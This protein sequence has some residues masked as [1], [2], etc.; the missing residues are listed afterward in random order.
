[1]GL[2]L[3][4][5]W[6][7]RKQK[8]KFA[9][10][11]DQAFSELMA[12]IRQGK[13]SVKI[14]ERTDGRALRVIDQPMEGGGWVATFE[15][16]TE[17][18][19]TE[20]ERDQNR[21]FLDLIIDNV[22]SAIFVKEAADRKYVLVNRSAE[23]LWG[24]PRDNIIGKTCEEVFSADEAE[25]IEGRADHLLGTTGP[26]FEERDIVTPQ[27][28]R[29]SIFCR[30]LVVQD[31]KGE[32][33][34]LLGVVDDVTDR[35]AAQARIAHLAYFD[36][37]TELPNRTSFREQLENELAFVARGARLSVLYIDLDHFKRINDTLGHLLGDQLLRSVST[38]LKSCLRECDL[39]ARLGGDEFAIVQTNLQDAKDAELL[40][41]RLRKEVLEVE[42]NLSGHCVTV[43]LSIGI[44]LSPND[45][46]E[47]EELLKHADLALYGAKAEGRGTYRYFEP[48]MNEQMKRRR[49]LEL[50][51]RRA[52]AEGQFELHYQPVVDLGSGQ[53]AGCEALIRW[54]H[55]ERGMIPPS[56]FI[57]VAEETGLI[58]PIGEWVVKKAC[59][60]AAKW[61]DHVVV[62]VNV[63]AIQFRNENLP[64]LIAKC[65]AQ[66]GLRPGR[67]EIEVTESVL[68]QD[69]ETTLSMLHQLQTLGVSI[70]MD[71]FGTGYSSLSYL[72][73]FPFDKIKIDR[74]FIA[75][76][77]H[78]TDAA[79]IVQAIL[80][81]AKSLRM[82]TTA[83]G[84][85]TVEQRALLQTIG[86]DQIQGFLF[87]PAVPAAE[88]SALLRICPDERQQRA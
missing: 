25:Q 1:M 23:E 11:P 39:I 5:L 52:L 87:S 54:R 84:V 26:V 80:S 72:R 28:G 77:A 6:R 48:L 62:A 15:D 36:A 8:G 14:L 4:T 61:P 50:D 56:E 75:D 44:A 58:I 55:P 21:A 34:Y 59:N 33:R 70:A 47:V 67:L 63:S 46:T 49:L 45:G 76:L 74:S 16:I 40:A 30:R 73:S 82:R 37:L 85:E 13:P 71:D 19:L 22:P 27:K 68:M 86:C 60:D 64:L 24:V 7:H 12:S 20:N 65:L 3:L 2:S 79:A 43:D 18:R 57:A 88:I 78:G 81:L 29:R 10:H 41:Q 51:L 9:G 35:K 17:Q 31:K 53:V 66:S 42:H 32:N 38:R 69:N 83:E